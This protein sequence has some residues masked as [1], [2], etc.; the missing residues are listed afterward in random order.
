MKKIVN[1][2]LIGSFALAIAACAR[3]PAPEYDLTPPPPK[4]YDAKTALET[5]RSR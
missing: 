5:G 3:K 2:I 1:L 4:A